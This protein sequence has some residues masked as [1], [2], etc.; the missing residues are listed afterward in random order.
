MTMAKKPKQDPKDKKA[1]SRVTSAPSKNKKGPTEP[2]SEKIGSQEEPFDLYGADLVRSNGD[3][4]AEAYKAEMRAWVRGKDPYPQIRHPKKRAALWALSKTMGIVT[5][6]CR[7]ANFGRDTHRVWVRDDSD[8]ADAYAHIQEGMLD[9]AETKLMERIKGVKVV[10]GSEVYDVPPDTTAIM[11][12]LNNRGGTRGYGNRVEVK[13][14]GGGGVIRPK[15]I[16]ELEK[17]NAGKDE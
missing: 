9:L 3:E 13:H 2:K 17:K 15:F 4:K 10:K 1:P 8:Y 16:E 6:A 12:V 7:L 14:T 11:F 5:S